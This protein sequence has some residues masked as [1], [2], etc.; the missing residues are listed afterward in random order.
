MVVTRIIALALK[1]LSA[2]AILGLAAL[3]GAASAAEPVRIGTSKTG[4]LVWLAD[5]KGYLDGLNI[6]LEEVGSGVVAANRVADGSLTFGTSSE[7]AFASKILTDR[8]LCLYGTISASRTTRLISRS[9]KIGPAPSDLRGASIAVTPNGIGQFFLS[10]YLILSDVD[11]D[12]VTL[13][14]ARPQ[15]IVELISDGKVDAAMTWE[16]HVTN[17]RKALGEIATDY[18]DQADQYYYFTLHGKCALSEETAETLT[19]FLEGLHKAENFA[20]ENPDE[21]KQA[22]AERLA[23]DAGS[24]EDIWPQHSLALVIPQDLISAIEAEMAWR[25]END[26]SE[27][28]APNVLDFLRPDPLHSVAPQAVRVVY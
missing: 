12:S 21:A 15:E 18:P 19:G 11:I 8:D 24:L 26:L 1:T 28:P 22:L 5:A 17:I 3:T 16:P 23:M 9:D 2:A 25:I 10:Q 13:V 20:R 14:S 6:E 27:G 4:M 7:F